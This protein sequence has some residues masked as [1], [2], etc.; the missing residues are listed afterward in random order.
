MFTELI[1]ILLTAS[2]RDCEGVEWL[3][4]RIEEDRDGAVRQRDIT[5]EW[6]NEHGWIEIISSHLPPGHCLASARSSALPRSSCFHV[7]EESLADNG[8]DRVRRKR[9]C[10]EKS[11][12]WPLAGE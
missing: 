12:L 10:D 4:F 1:S 7:E 2:D 6:L 11:R 5:L 3:R 9:L 8:F